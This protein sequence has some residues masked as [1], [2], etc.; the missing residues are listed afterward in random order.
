MTHPKPETLAAYHAGEL[1]DGEAQPLQEHLLACR[2]CAALLLDLDSLAD[3]GFGA[4][5]LSA[6]DQEALWG[7]I[8]GKI[9][10][11]EPALVPVIPLRRPSRFSPQPRWLQA[12]AAALLVATVGLSVWVVSLRRTVESLNRP[13]PN[14]PVID[15]YSGTSR[16]AGSPQPVAIV[17][18]DFRFFTVIL[19]PPHSRSTNRYRVEI[20]RAGGGSV[21]SRDGVAPDPLGPLPLTLTRSL[22][23]PGEYRIRLFEETGN[24]KEPLVDYGLRVE[25]P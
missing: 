7:R 5:S 22:I 1:P 12:L 14:A 6:A 18:S 17:P 23:G 19:H 16:S 20:A 2:E 8:E 9:Q 24:P 15:L 11:E 3:P 4:G 13:E 25:G 21:W 10:E